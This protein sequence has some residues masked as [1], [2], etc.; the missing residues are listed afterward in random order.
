[1]AGSLDA[2]TIRSNANRAAS[3]QEQQAALDSA[4]ATNAESAGQLGILTSIASGAS[5]VASKWQSMQQAGVI[6]GGGAPSYASM[7]P[8]N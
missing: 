3:G 8:V 2:Y 1:M 4:G 7:R 6:G 5:S